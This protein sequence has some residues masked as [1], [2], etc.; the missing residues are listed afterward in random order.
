MQIKKWLPK[1]CVLN[2]FNSNILL[3]WKHLPIKEIKAQPTIKNYLR[4]ETN[5]LNLKIYWNK[6]RKKF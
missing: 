1:F 5:D 3:K 2:L 4:W 6:K